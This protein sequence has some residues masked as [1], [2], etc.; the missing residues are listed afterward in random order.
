MLRGW[1]RTLTWADFT[2]IPNP[3]PGQLVALNGRAI[4][5]RVSISIMFYPETS[6]VLPDT[7]ILTGVHFG[8]ADVSVILNRGQMQYVPSRIPRGQQAYYL[9]HEQGHL[10]LMGLFARELYVR[11]MALRAVDSAGL[12][13]AADREVD[14]AVGS[15]R[16]YAI[17]PPHSDCIY[18]RE[19]HHGQRRQKQDQWNH[20]IA[21]NIARW[22]EPNFR[23][24]M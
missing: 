7:G 16:M 17:N 19:T 8:D 22:Q 2:A 12:L 3:G 1:P 20:R 23:V 9:R 11:L 21:Q 5:A 10:D 6:Q 13:R 4:V 18:D 15:A 24:G 14:A